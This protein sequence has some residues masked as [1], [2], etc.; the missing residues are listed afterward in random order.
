MAFPRATLCVSCKQKRRAPLT[1]GGTD[2]LPS[3][4]TRRRAASDPACVH[5]RRDAW[6]C[7]TWPARSSLSSPAVRP[8]CRSSCWVGVLT[9]T[10]TR[11]PGAAFSIGTGY[12]GSSLCRDRRG[13]HHRARFDGACVPRTGVGARARPAAGRRAGQPHRPRLPCPGPGRGYVV[14]LLELPHLPVFNLADSA[15][16]RRRCADGVPRVRG[17]GP[18]GSTA[19]TTAPRPARQRASLWVSS[20]PCRCPTASTANGSMRRWPGCSAFRA[21]R[22]PTS[23]RPEACARRGG[24]RRSPTG[25]AP[26]PGSRCC[27]RTARAACRW[28]PSRWPG[29]RIVHDDDDIVVV[30]KPVGVAAHPS[31]G[32]AGP[33]VSAGWPVAGYRIATSGAAERQGIVHRLDVGTSGLMVVAKSERAYT[34][35]KH[36][37]KERTVDKVYHA[38]VQGHPDPLTGTIDA[39]IARHPVTT[40]AGRWSPAASRASRT[41][42]RWRRSARHAARDPPRDW[43]HPSDPGAHEPHCAIRASATS[44]T[45][46]TPRS[47]SGSDSTRQW[48]HALGSASNIRRQGSGSSSQSDYPPTWP[49]RSTRCELA[50]DADRCGLADVGPARSPAARAAFLSRD[51]AAVGAPASGDVTLVRRGGGRHTGVCVVE[52]GSPRSCSCST[53]DDLDAADTSGSR[54]GEGSGPRARAGQGAAS[55]GLR[56]VDLRGQRAALAGCTSGTAC[57]ARRT[58][59]SAAKRAAA[60]RAATCPR[61]CGHARRP[62]YER[63]GYV[64][65]G[66]EFDD[67]GSLPRHMRKHLR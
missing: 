67:A 26:A 8:G 28:W 2:R 39:P 12:T 9:L 3:H 15:I 52:Q 10:Y 55:G 13:G 20:A 57:V 1:G 54:T 4:P 17:I 60:R 50:T 62:V 27:C 16:V 66:E 31:P 65:Y 64:A 6:S 46:P 53:R 21:P 63:L 45:A 5:R 58:T 32:W 42:R 44:P 37:F 56:A 49:T 48:L 18:D 43:P 19:E 33:T 40:T 35:L 41:T 14:D 7:S 22:P 34:L 36:A 25:C 29:L 24:R 59:D 30:D 51:D 38:L 61:Q 23:P 47:R 11:N